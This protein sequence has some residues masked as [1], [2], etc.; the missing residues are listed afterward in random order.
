MNPMSTD[1]LQDLSNNEETI[2]T[3]IDEFHAVLSGL[4]KIRDKRLFRH[5]GFNSFNDYCHQKYQMSEEMLELLNIFY[6]P[7]DPSHRPMPP[8]RTGIKLQVEPAQIIR[9]ATSKT[10]QKLVVSL[11]GGGRRWNPTLTGEAIT[12]QDDDTELKI[13]CDDLLGFGPDA[14]IAAIAKMG[15]SVAQTFLAMVSYW[16]DTQRG[17]THESYTTV[18]VSDLMRHMGKKEIGTGG[19]HSKDIIARGREV[20]LLG[21]INVHSY[22]DT[23]YNK[24]PPE[25]RTMTMGPLFIIQTTEFQQSKSDPL[26]SSIAFRYHLSGALYDWVSGNNVQY[27][28]ISAKI[29]HYHPYNQKYHVLL[30]F[31]LAYY[32]RVNGLK[33]GNRTISL[34]ALLNL[35]GIEMPRNNLPRFTEQIARVIEELAQDGVIPGAVL[36]LDTSASISS[37]KAIKNASVVFPSLHE[38]RMVDPFE[39]APA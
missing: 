37:R 3:G 23:N 11:C 31:C 30:G 13:D 26:C 38:L 39:R 2:R 12:Y 22:Q 24:K 1:E 19:Y 34:P 35:A 32:D 7:Q 15:P 9:V 21:K 16:L 20:W 27:K 14:A 36:T 25:S 8:A 29:L 28:D 17:H 6:P 10:M 33:G 5:Y 18:R 4:A